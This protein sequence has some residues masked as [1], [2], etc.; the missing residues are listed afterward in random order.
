VQP[1]GSG[2]TISITYSDC[3]FVALGMQHAMRMRHTVICGFSGSTIFFQI[4]H[5]RHDFRKNRIVIEQKVC[6]FSLQRLSETFLILR[7]NERD[8]IKKLC[9]DL[10]VKYRYSSPILMDLYFSRQIFRKILVQ[11]II[12]IRPVGAELFRADR[13]TDRHD[14]AKSRS[15]QICERA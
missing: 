6:V 8:M 3:L 7:R 11:Q 10:Y 15:S 4:F 1:C 2:K 14:E 13:Q 5:K 12:K 9:I